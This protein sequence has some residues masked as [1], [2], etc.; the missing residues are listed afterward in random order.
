MNARLLP[1][2]VVEKPWGREALPAQFGVAPGSPVGEIWFE[3]PP[4]MP[5]LLIKYLFTSERLSVQVH[6]D[7]EQA[8]AAGLGRK[9][10]EEC[11]LVLDA[12]PGAQI[13]LGFRQDH[14]LEDIRQGALDGAIV[15]ML[16]WQDVAPGDFIYVPAGTVHAIGAGLTLVEIQQ[17]SDITYRLY[18]YG[19]PRELHLD[20]GLAVTMPGLHD[21]ALR[22]EATPGRLVDGP[23]FT[24]D[25]IDGESETSGPALVVPLSGEVAGQGVSARA[26]QCLF[27]SEAAAL[28]AEGGTRYLVA[29][30]LADGEAV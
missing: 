22:R 9:G 7:D 28:E 1:V 2:S 24:L 16:S 27:V 15:D 4:Q 11:W 12:E 10:K 30:S 17:T 20:A 29:R 5:D 19:R 8:E 14:A 13:G 21:P 6:P 25:L 18:D 23:Y 26:G 3:P